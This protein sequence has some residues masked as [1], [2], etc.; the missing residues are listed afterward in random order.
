MRLPYKLNIII[1]RM[2]MHDNV[3]HFSVF[4]HF[5]TNPPLYYLVP[6][7]SATNQLRIDA[8]PYAS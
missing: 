1:S 2:A 6:Y 5:R 7:Q 8:C 4:N 3:Y